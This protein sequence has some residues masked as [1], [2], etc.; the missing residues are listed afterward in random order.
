M[1]NVAGTHGES[2]WTCAV[3]EAS[4]VFRVSVSKVSQSCFLFEKGLVYVIITMITLD[5]A[6][7][8][9]C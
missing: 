1:S 6:Y 7:K 3:T 8:G 5:I 9:Y 2:V 4:S